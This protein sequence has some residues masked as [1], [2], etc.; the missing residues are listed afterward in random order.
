MRAL[1]AVM[2]AGALLTTYS[3][4][5]SAVVN[6]DFEDQTP[7]FFPNNLTIGNFRF[8]PSCHYDIV[9][10]RPVYQSQW[11]GFDGSACGLPGSTNPNFLGP[12]GL[13]PSLWVDYS[14]TPFSL[15]GL[16]PVDFPAAQRPT[17]ELTSSN[18][19][20]FSVP[21][22]SPSPAAF[23]GPAWTNISWLL[24]TDRQSAGRPSGF[25]NISFFVP[26]QPRA[27]PEPETWALFAGAGLAFLATRRRPGRQ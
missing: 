18:G 24:F 19:G 22:G 7:G 10:A 20:F 27:L 15:L 23:S 14:A 21:F 25:D 12:A 4:V 1:V 26:E 5:E 16:L 8:S 17:W 9:P 11:I 3:H 2:L 13:P 6:I